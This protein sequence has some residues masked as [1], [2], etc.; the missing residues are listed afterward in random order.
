[1]KYQEIV[2]KL[3]AFGMKFGIHLTGGSLFL[4]HLQ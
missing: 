2:G 3:D 4:Q 1:M